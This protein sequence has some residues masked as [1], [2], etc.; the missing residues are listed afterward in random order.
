MWDHCAWQDALGRCDFL[1]VL[2][3]AAVV[4]RPVQVK[5]RSGAS[6]IDVVKDVE[7]KNGEEFVTFDSS[8]TVKLSEIQG[9]SRAEPPRH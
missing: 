3:E 8:G 7:T 5:L 1:D 6:F 4:K 9:M 2:E